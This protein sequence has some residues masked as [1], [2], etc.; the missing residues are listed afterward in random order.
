MRRTVP[1]DWLSRLGVRPTL[2]K[3]AP[4][5]RRGGYA[6]DIRGAAMTVADRMGI[7]GEV[8]RAVTGMR[9]ASVVDGTGRV[10]ARVKSE[11][12]LSAPGDVEIK[13]GDLSRILF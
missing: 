13:R 5:L 1:A 11:H 10:L 3:P 9:G 4:S 2:V 12:I 7:G 8:R 6:V